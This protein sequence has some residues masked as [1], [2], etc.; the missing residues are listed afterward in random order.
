MFLKLKD[1]LASCQ[2]ISLFV[3]AEGEA[4]TVTVIPKPKCDSEAALKTP[5]VLTGTADELEAGFI[6]AIGTYTQAHTSLAD[7]VRQTAEVLDSAKQQSAAKAVKQAVKSTPT[8]TSI[9][10]LT[11]DEERG[12]TE[13][14]SQ[15]ASNEPTKEAAATSAAD[16]DLGSLL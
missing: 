16:L 15:P 7:Q 10:D 14:S 6:D 4:M 5:L 12:S 11:P 9:S 2:S 3:T 13:S 8:P 1:L